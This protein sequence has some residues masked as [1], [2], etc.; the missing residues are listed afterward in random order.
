MSAYTYLPSGVVQ[1]LAAI[2]PTL[3]ARLLHP[4]TYV[5]Y[6]FLYHRVTFLR[7]LEKKSHIQIFFPTPFNSYDEQEFDLIIE[8]LFREIRDLIFGTNFT[9]FCFPFFFLILR[10]NYI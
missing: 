10:N 9:Y 2:S 5:K 1:S 8:Y 3:L 6:F 4:G 7:F